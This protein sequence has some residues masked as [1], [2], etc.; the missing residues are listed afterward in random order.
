M[1]RVLLLLN[2]F[3][4]NLYACQGGYDSC[5]RKII[6][7]STVVGKNLEI[8]ISQNKRLI[9]TKNLKTSNKNIIK[10]DLFLSLYLVKNKK[11][12]RYPFRFNKHQSLGVASVN[13]IKAIEGIVKKRQIGLNSFAK[14]NNKISS[15]SLLITSCC[16]LE[17]I[18]T[19][20]GVI[21]KDYIRHFL[22]SKNKFYGDIG[23][24][25]SKIA[26]KIIVSENDPFMLENQFKKGDLILKF[27]G[28][29]IYRISSL[30][31]KIL[32]SKIGKK[33]R[34]QVKRNSK[35]LNLNVVVNRRYG[36]GFLS[37]TFLEQ[38][39]IFFDK[40][41][42]IT[43]IEVRGDH[44]GLKVG[45]HLLKANDVVVKNQKNLRKYIG[46]F[47]KSS[48]LLFERNSFQFFVKIKRDD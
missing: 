47:K 43:K 15:P 16:S 23:I 10:K 32:F 21:E 8:P 3:F 36:G 37:D 2:L 13:K 48:L 40:N 24:R 33:Y 34:V 46:D 45:D 30:M 6:D 11:Y 12:F 41:L 27:D 35:I 7:S 44:Y 9:F 31:K 19:P 4:L 26:R 22:Y 5:K 28:K 29:K 17:G 25:I 18:V 39:G 42:F 14:F 38:K 20:R 1:L